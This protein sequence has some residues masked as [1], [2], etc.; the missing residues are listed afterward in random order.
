MKNKIGAISLFLIIHLSL[1]IG[2]TAH[3]APLGKRIV[4]ENGMVLLLSE[5]H[6]IPSVTINMLIKAGQVAEPSDKAG[7]AHITAGL[8]TE[9]TK[10][11]SSSQIAEEI[12]FVGGGIGASGGDDTASVNLTVLK[13]DLDLGL[14]ILSDILLNPAFP[15]A[16]I[17]RKVKETKAGIEKEKDDPSAIAGKEFARLLFGEHP[18]GRLT[19]GTPESLDK[20]TREDI[21]KFH[22][23][24]YA[25]NN[26]IMAVVGD[27][28]EEE[29]VSRLNKYLGGWSQRELPK[30]I[31]PVVKPPKHK[32]VKPMDKKITQANIV[33]GNIG[34]ERE[35]PDYYAAY[36]MNYILG[37]GGFTSRLMDN[38]RDTKGLAY[39]VHSYF[40]PM[41]YSGSF[42]IGVQTKNESAK[43]A[44]EEALKEVERIRKET[45]SDK[46]L[47][48]AKAYL[49]GSFPLKLDTN[50]KIAGMLA[51]FEFFNL[52][53][54][55]PEKYPKIINS[56]TKDDVLKA[57]KKYLSPDN[58]ILVVVGDIEKAGV[59]EIPAGVPKL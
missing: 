15:E 54:D 17:K 47:E 1:L 20:M 56:L 48:D 10:K 5:R 29:I 30:R 50:S 45:V 35:N 32:I 51:A 19:E 4:L 21:V 24:Y 44:I 39:D 31:L 22:A 28:T 42:N 6:T 41:K 38:I 36:V 27:V 9:G 53:L 40:S 57:A 55:Y 18:Y 13:K 2:A 23:A 58:Y 34:L 46:E 11:R 3:A 7:L 43:T 52:G 25:P 33:L 12:E 37:G 49:T 8:L 14:D 16:E 59:K 26:A